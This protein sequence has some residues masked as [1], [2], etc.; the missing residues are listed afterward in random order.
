MNFG[1]KSRGLLVELKRS[2]WLPP[3]N[4]DA[5]RGVLSEIQA[6]F[7]ELSDTLGGRTTVRGIYAI[8]VP[9]RLPRR[10]PCYPVVL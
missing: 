7:D 9:F 5:V 4:E 1:V 8:A 2:D 6:L 10:L 3:Y